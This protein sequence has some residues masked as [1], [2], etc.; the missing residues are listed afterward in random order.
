MKKLLLIICISILVI[1]AA[2]NETLDDCSSVSCLSDEREFVFEVLDPTS[3][4]NVFSN[5]TLNPDE[6]TVTNIVAESEALSVNYNEVNHTIEIV[7]DLLNAESLELEVA[8]AGQV[9]FNFFVEYSFIQGKC[10]TS[11]ALNQM[12]IENSSY[13]VNVDTN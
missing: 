3:G 10:C 13:T 11:I 1:S 9:I 12:S 4:E 7:E 2:C 8:V 6:I 5:G